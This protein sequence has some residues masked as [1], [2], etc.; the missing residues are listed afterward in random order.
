MIELLHGTSIIAIC[1]VVSKPVIGLRI[2]L[3]GHGPC[4]RNDKSTAT[5]VLPYTPTR[6]DITTVAVAL[7]CPPS[8]KDPDA[9]SLQPGIR[10][11]F[12]GS[13]S[14]MASPVPSHQERGE[15]GT[16]A[17]YGPRPTQHRGMVIIG[18]ESWGRREQP[19]NLA[20]GP[21]E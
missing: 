2:A 11:R 8:S 21:L 6:A 4:R 1:V 20:P 14:G 5:T 3:S 7:A 9:Q 19:R 16:G 12:T 17:A 13:R 10:I 18:R 15:I